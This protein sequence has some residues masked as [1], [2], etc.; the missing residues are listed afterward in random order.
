MKQMIKHIILLLFLAW[1]GACFSQSVQNDGNIALNWEI[2]DPR[3]DGAEVDA[4]L[5]EIAAFI[6]EN[7]Q[8]IYLVTGHVD[9]RWRGPYSVK[10]TLKRAQWVTQSLLERL[11]DVGYHDSYRP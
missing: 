3:F 10:L 5:N 7:P 1:G 11:G 9:E 2:Y 6:K 8:E 4:Q